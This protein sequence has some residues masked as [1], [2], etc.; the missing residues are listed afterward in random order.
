MQ[1]STCCW[2]TYPLMCQQS[3]KS[4][5]DESVL[6]LFLKGKTKITKLLIAFLS[7]RVSFQCLKR[8]KVLETL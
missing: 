4:R 5:K 8:W 2:H 1:K 7:I 6:W 3:E